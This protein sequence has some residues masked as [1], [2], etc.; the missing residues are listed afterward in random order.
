MLA[1]LLEWFNAYRVPAQHLSSILLAAAIWRWGGAPERWVIAIFLATMV[2]PIY[3]LRWLGVQYLEIGSGAA[4][5][6]FLDLL[7]AALFVGV[8][9]Q[10]NRNYPLWIA[11]FQL[12]A[13]GAHLVRSLID[14][15]NP[16]ALAVLV[17]GPSYCQLLLIF[18]G[19]LRHRARERRFGAYREWRP[20]STGLQWWRA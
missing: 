3:P 5:G 7:A 15:I 12:V 2:V 18:G 19:F 17:I 11:G 10:A 14:G 1:D 8:A 13:V 16:F 6:F 4:L 9:L 20:G